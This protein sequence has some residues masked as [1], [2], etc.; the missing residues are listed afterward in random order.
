MYHRLLK[1]N[2]IPELILFDI[3]EININFHNIEYYEINMELIWKEFAEVS[4]NL[5]K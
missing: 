2:I 5:A 4:K 3:M 1:E